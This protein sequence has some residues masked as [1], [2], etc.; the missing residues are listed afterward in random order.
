[1]GMEMEIEQVN[2]N[3]RK[4]GTD[5]KA[6]NE[7]RR[8]HEA[9]IRSRLTAVE[10]GVARI[11]QEG[12]VGSYMMAAQLAPQALAKF[13]EDPAFVA[14]S[15]AARRGMKPS[16]FSAR[17]NMDGSI[18]AAL[19]GDT[20]SG[21]GLV[22]P[23]RNPNIVTGPQRSLR[24]LDVMPSRPT[25]TDAVEFVTLNSTG[26]VSEQVNQGDTKAELDFVG[27]LDRAEIATI[28]GW[29]AAS[30]QVL[31]D[32]QG[33]QAA[34]NRVIS[35]KLMSRLENQLIN[36]PGT[37]G[38]INGLLTQAVTFV[39]AVGTIQAENAADRIGEALMAQERAGYRPN[40]IVLNPVDW[41]LMQVTKSQDNDYLFGSP[42]APVPQTLWNRTVV[43]TESMPEGEAMTLD[44]AYTTVLDREQM[45]IAVSNQHADFFVRNLVAILG[46]LRAG[47]EVLDPFA[48]QK[49]DFAGMSSI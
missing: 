34:I 43:V 24:L 12:I 9:E 31:A 14:A 13:Q 2:A 6:F 35:N 1:M 45:T 19:T 21:T 10:Q 16:Q 25:T 30:K 23:Q 3:L 11:D 44:T 47:L 37:T 29:T 27:D 41:F 46:E 7:E 17:I 33:L 15:D 26:D 42:I 40:L 5:L 28:A 49:F 32:A 18:R 20:S 36:G 48:V 8:T 4:V 22:V 39:P 38:K